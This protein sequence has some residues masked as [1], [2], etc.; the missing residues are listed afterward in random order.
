MTLEQLFVDE[1]IE[2][3]GIE[4]IQ[5]FY[6]EIKPLIDSGKLKIIENQYE[7]NSLDNFEENRRIGENDSYIC[8]LIRH[9]KIQEFIMYV[10]KKKVPYKTFRVER[11]IFETNSFLLTK[12]STLIEYAAFFGSIQ[13]FQFLLLN[14]AELTSSLWLYAIHGQNAEIIHI[15]E[16]NKVKLPND[17]YEKCFV[18]AVKCHHNDIANYFKDNFILE[19]DVNENIF[20]CCFRY[21]NYEHFPNDITLYHII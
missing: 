1:I 2:N 14:E 11:S 16:E 17:S 6:P 10:N 15:L 19:K 7:P 18:E 9:D 8:D 4:F 12:E 3:E 21:Y 5:F 13:I 20:T